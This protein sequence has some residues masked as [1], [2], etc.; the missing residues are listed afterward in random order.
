MGAYPSAQHPP[1]FAAWPAFPPTT[2]AAFSIG[3]IAEVK[4]DSGPI[5]RISTSA[6]D[7]ERGLH[8]LEIRRRPAFFRTGIAFTKTLKPSSQACGVPNFTV[9]RQVMPSRPLSPH[10]FFATHHRL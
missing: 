8:R 7:V 1:Y 9:H 4:S 5:S 3:L 10:S 6:D 2:P